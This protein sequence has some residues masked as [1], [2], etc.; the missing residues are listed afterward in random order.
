MKSFNNSLVDG[1]GLGTSR[2]PGVS[3][4][5]LVGAG[6]PKNNMP[7]VLAL[8]RIA[9]P[10][11]V[12]SIVATKDRFGSLGSARG[13]P[14]SLR[15]SEPRR[16]FLQRDKSIFQVKRNFLSIQN[17]LAEPLIDSF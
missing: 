13:V 14:D 11:A 6:K 12:A 2:G 5:P 1:S 9:M 17:G 16:R 7:K 15:V 4:V 3:S 10:G 8:L